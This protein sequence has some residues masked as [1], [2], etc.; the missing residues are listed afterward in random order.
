MQS[1]V[2]DLETPAA[3]YEHVVQ[4]YLNVVWRVARRCGVHDSQ[5]DDVIQ[6]VFLVVARRLDQVEHGRERAFVIGV[7]TRVAAN[8]RRAQ[9]RCLEDPVAWLEELPAAGESPGLEVVERRQGLLLLQEALDQM[10]DAQR[11][12]FVL[13]ELEQLTAVE[14]AL[15]LE[16]E[17]AAVVSRLRRS[18]QVFRRF[19]ERRRWEGAE[20][21]AENVGVG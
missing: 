7:T 14:I 10:T 5:L 16:L 17:E 6:E 4:R 11:E 8:W 15:Q 20:P 1:L 3:R 18:R 13:A 21:C 9:R 19:C 2:R 12:V